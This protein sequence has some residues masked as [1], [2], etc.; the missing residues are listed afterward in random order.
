MT[1]SMPITEKDAKYVFVSKGNVYEIS[2]QAFAG[3]AAHAGRTV[4]LTGEMTGNS[5]A[6]SEIRVP[7][8]RPLARTA[9]R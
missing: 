4:R 8:M 9:P 1:I 5:I 2:N 3:L 7:T 6:V